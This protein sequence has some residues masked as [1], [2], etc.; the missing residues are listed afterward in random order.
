MRVLCCIDLK[1]T[2]YE[3]SQRNPASTELEAYLAGDALVGSFLPFF[4]ERSQL[5]V[6]GLSRGLRK[7]QTKMG[8]LK[9]DEISGENAWRP[10][11]SNARAI[12]LHGTARGVPLC[13]RSA[14]CGH[15]GRP[16]RKMLHHTRPR[17]TAHPFTARCQYIHL[18]SRRFAHCMRILQFLQ[19]DG[20]I[21][22]GASPK[23]SQAFRGL[24][25]LHDGMMPLSIG[26]QSW[27]FSSTQ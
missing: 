24:M 4:P 2:H 22:A 7:L 18:C 1:S 16:E 10:S 20:R 6:A 25:L 11:H 9:E 12:F 5:P 14:A 21:T 3:R 23:I 26:L 27:Y 8:T 15:E 13:A 17:Q 19:I